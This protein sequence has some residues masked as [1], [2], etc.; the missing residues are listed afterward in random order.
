MNLISN[1]EGH[2]IPIRYDDF[3]AS[4]LSEFGCA[5]FPADD[6][7]NFDLPQAVKYLH[8]NADTLGQIDATTLRVADTGDKKIHCYHIILNRENR[9]S[10][11]GFF[12]EIRRLC[13]VFSIEQFY[14]CDF[15]AD[16]IYIFTATTIEDYGRLKDLERLLN[17]NSSRQL[18]VR[19]M[20]WC[21]PPEYKYIHTPKVFRN[22]AERI[23][24]E[25]FREH[26]GEFKV[27]YDWN[28]CSANYDDNTHTLSFQ[29]PTVLEFDINNK[30]LTIKAGT[31]KTRNLNI[32][33]LSANSVYG[34]FLRCV[35]C[36][37]NCIFAESVE[38]QNLETKAVHTNI[39][40]GL[41]IDANLGQA[42]LL[43]IINQNLTN[44]VHALN[45]WHSPYLE[46]L[47]RFK[48]KRGKLVYETQHI[49][50]YHLNLQHAE[51]IKRNH[52]TS[53]I[54]FSTEPPTI[55]AQVQFFQAENPQYA[56]LD[57]EIWAVERPHVSYFHTADDYRYLMIYNKQIRRENEN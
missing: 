37:V 36:R 38:C 22:D 5:I 19:H 23:Y 7:P 18:C 29:R 55:E 8:E 49:F 17:L 11:F 27:F 44:I 48:D 41:K 54:T 56:D 12:D 28:E 57:L 35:N 1:S 34:N 39:N 10:P 42:N 13:S 47:A 32:Q 50:A 4:N 26:L 3:I 6:N 30:L 31:L 52:S 33:D 45:N 9:L 46:R 21:A 25:N 15:H 20:K 43:Q 40:Y 24:Y 53:E 2:F 16:K 51:T 14:A